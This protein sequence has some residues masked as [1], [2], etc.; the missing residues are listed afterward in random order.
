MKWRVSPI[1][2]PRIPDNQPFVDLDGRR[3]LYEGNSKFR[4]SEEYL[5][6]R[7]QIRAGALTGAVAL[8]LLVLL[9]VKIFLAIKRR[10]VTLRSLK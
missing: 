10:W 3:V 5:D 1:F 2:D 9:N 4:P 6:R 8:A 7:V